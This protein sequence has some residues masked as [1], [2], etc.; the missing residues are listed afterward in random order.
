MGKE[1]P[2]TTPI[3]W[4]KPTADI[5]ADLL[6]P[7]WVP[8]NAEVTIG[9]IRDSIGL[10][11]QEYGLV[12]ST[13]EGAIA[14][15]RADADPAKR[16]QGIDLHDALSAMLSRGISLSSPDRQATIDL[17]AAFG[18]WPDAVR[19]AVKAVGG[20][21]VGRWSLEGFDAEPMLVDVETRK[22]S[23]MLAIAAQERYRELIATRNRW[24]SVA[25]AVRSL[26]ESGSVGRDDVVVKVGELW[27][28]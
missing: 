15:L 8:T 23:V 18:Q 14:T 19:D 16:M 20:V 26:I 22:Q 6:V 3:D 17:L 5:L 11:P 21:W 1:M 12:R 10:T 25:S 7:V 2:D 24:D 28:L 4:T 9:M 13:L 27:Q